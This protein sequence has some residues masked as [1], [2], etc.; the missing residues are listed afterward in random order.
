MTY[1]GGPTFLAIGIMCVVG[2]AMLLTPFSGSRRHAPGWVRLTLGTV[3]A[4]C[5]LWAGL[6]CLLRFSGQH[7]S[8]PAFQ[9][10]ITCR[11]VCSGA[12]L[13]AIFL[14]IVSGGFSLAFLS[15]RGPKA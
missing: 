2:I 14:L 9:L 6:S 4:A 5:L 15:R 10:L 8:P 13:C 11:Q 7:F 12:A 3:G 1:H